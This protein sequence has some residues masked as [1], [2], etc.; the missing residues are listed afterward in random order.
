MIKLDLPESTPTNNALLRQHW[1]KY[2]Q[3]RKHWSMLV[4]MA[5]SHA[6]IHLRTT[7]PVSVTIIRYGKQPLDPD[8]LV[9]GCKVLIDALKDHG[10]IADDSPQ[11]LTLAV[12]QQI[13]QMARTQVSIRT[14]AEAKLSLEASQ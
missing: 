4:M 5:K 14:I 3:I 11:Y 10:L 6:R 2:R 7:Q 8:N 9:G 1:T 12:S 13:D